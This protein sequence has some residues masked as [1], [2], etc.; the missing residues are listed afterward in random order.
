MARHHIIQ[1]SDLHLGKTKQYNQAGW[2]ACLAHINKVSPE[3][4]AVTGDHVFDDMDCDEDHAYVRHQLDRLNSKWKAI[5]G[6][7]D[8]GD[9]H[10]EP[11]ENQ[12]FN[13]ERLYRYKRHFRDDRWSLDLGEW[14]LIGINSFLPGSG[15]SPLEEEHA[16]WLAK[17]VSSAE[18]RPIAL[19]SHKPLCVDKLDE[20]S[21]PYFCITAAGRDQILSTIRQ[22]NIRF[23]GCGH[24]HHYRTVST[25][26][27]PMIWAP[28]T[29]QVF[30]MERPYTGLATPGFVNFWLDDNGDFEFGLTEPQGIVLNNTNAMVSHFGRMRN[31][32]DYIWDG[33]AV[34][35]QERVLG[36]SNA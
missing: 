34:P 18:G 17:A 3:F 1:I 30:T 24:N 29:S 35:P 15:I 31:L 14:R 11:Y 7:H 26:N 21:D 16:G 5:P 27:L 19:F 23:I 13:E 6:N 9:T 4:V 25:N 32:P 33:E 20:P 36:N 22:A 2:E 12:H 8:I 10:P 28:S